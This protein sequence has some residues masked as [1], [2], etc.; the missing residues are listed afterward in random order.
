MK[1]FL[2]ISRRVIFPP[3]RDATG[4]LGHSVEKTVTAALRVLFFAA[5]LDQPDHFPRMSEESIR[6]SLLMP[7]QHIA[8]V[9]AQTVKLATNEG[10]KVTILRFA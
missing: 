4:R 3:K 9:Y 1:T 7:T 8:E 6:Q 5:A 2:V 10:A